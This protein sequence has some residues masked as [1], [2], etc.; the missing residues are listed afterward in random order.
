[1]VLLFCTQGAR[2]DIVLWG[3]LAYGF[4]NFVLILVTR[5]CSRDSIWSKVQDRVMRLTNPQDNP[6]T[7]SLYLHL[8]VWVGSA[9]TPATT[10]H[11]IA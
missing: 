4:V 9:T 5:L 7:V 1:M 10:H 3:L 8:A 6:S 11:N 2:F